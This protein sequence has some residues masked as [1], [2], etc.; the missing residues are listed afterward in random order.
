[1]WFVLYEGYGGTIGRAISGPSILHTGAIGS[2]AGFGPH[3]LEPNWG[4]HDPGTMCVLK[5]LQSDDPRQPGITELGFT[6]L[7][8]SLDRRWEVYVTY[9]DGSTSE[10]RIEQV[11]ATE[12]DASGYL[13]QDDVFFLFAAPS[14]RTIV[15]LRWD[16]DVQGSMIDD[17]AFIIN[18]NRW[19][20]LLLIV[21]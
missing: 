14:G 18:P 1:V 15:E 20:G 9:D 3:G 10:R 19:R 11:A 16:N 8:S 21:L 13:F 7:C 12:A 2:G 17:L 6:A 4:R 5:F